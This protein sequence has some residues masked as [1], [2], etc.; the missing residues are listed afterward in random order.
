MK[1]KPELK[2]GGRRR[3]KTF[4]SKFSGGSHKIVRTKKQKGG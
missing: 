1:S 3:G 4:E 2:Q